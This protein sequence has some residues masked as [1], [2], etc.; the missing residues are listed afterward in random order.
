MHT[1]GIY[2]VEI[3]INCDEVDCEYSE[4]RKLESFEGFEFAT[5]EES[6][7]FSSVCAIFFN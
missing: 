1:L 7:G 3:R 6:D 5:T 4:K 2:T